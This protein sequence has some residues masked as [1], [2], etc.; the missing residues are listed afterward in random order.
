MLI[1]SKFEGYSRDGIRLY[2]CDDGG[3]Q[4]SPASSQTSISELPDWARGYAKDALAKTAALTD[5]SQNPYKVYGADRIAGFVGCRRHRKGTGECRRGN[6]L[7]I[8][9]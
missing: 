3:N 6:S 1:R 8:W 9:T 5:T 2:P 4:Q 7:Q